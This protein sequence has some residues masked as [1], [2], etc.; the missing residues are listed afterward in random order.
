M[1]QISIHKKSLSVAIGGIKSAITKFAREKN[2]EF[3]WQPRFHD[4]IIRNQTSM[5]EI[6]EYIE[7]NIARW[8]TDCFNE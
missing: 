2:I 7:N 8:K 4:N 1:P 5:N 6:A 3:A